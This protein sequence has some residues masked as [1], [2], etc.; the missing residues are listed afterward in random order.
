MSS[1][2]DLRVDIRSGIPRGILNILPL[3]QHAAA[4]KRIGRSTR[5]FAACSLYT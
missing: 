3:G 5:E 4:M 2:K 1:G